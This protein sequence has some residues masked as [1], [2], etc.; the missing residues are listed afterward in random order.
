M[1]DNKLKGLRKK[2]FAPNWF[3][4]FFSCHAICPTNLFEIIVQILN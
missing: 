4:K 2:F 3:F 1:L